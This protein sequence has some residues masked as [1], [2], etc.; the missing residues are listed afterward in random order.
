MKQVY[1]TRQLAS[2][3]LIGGFQCELG[4]I[5]KTKR[6]LLREKWLVLRADYQEVVA[7]GETDRIASSDIR[8]FL[9][10]L[11]FS[12]KH[13]F[14]LEIYLKNITESVII[15]TRSKIPSLL[16]IFSMS[17]LISFFLKGINEC[18][19]KS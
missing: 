11:S 3:T 9:K 17:I 12:L 4:Y 1:N 8:G 16:L 14:F 18:T 15:F 7:I 5:Y 2:D 19:S 13:S 10:V 6:H